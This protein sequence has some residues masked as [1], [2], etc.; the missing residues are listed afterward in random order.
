MTKQSVNR[1][2]QLKFVRCYKG[3]NQTELSK[4]I[5]GLSQSNLS[6]FEK[7]FEGQISEEKLK[8]VMEFLQWPFAW[9]DIKSPNPEFS[10]SF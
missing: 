4:E 9:L 1:G 2:R 3:Y 5:K 8:E 10:P 6:K 7:G